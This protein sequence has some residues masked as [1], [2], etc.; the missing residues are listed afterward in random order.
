MLGSYRRRTVGA[1]SAA[2]GATMTLVVGTTTS[3]QAATFVNG[4]ADSLYDVTRALADEYAFNVDPNGGD[5]LTAPAAPGTFT[6]AKAACNAY[7]A[8]HPLPTNA[9]VLPLERAQV[10]PNCFAFARTDVTPPTPTDLTYMGLRGVTPEGRPPGGALRCRTG[11]RWWSG[12]G[13]SG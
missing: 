5:W 3:A 8:T 4:G 13:S 2:L 12:I 7:Y 11:C 10:V 9:D 6:F 1:L